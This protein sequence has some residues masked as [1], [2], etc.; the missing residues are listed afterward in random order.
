MINEMAKSESTGEMYVTTRCV[1]EKGDQFG[2]TALLLNTRRNATVVAQSDVEL[3]VID[4]QVPTVE[5]Y[6]IKRKF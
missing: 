3:L 5:N 6:M 1:L 2:E 4:K